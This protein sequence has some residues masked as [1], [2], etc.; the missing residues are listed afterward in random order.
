MN[1]T[2]KDDNGDRVGRLEFNLP[3]TVNLPAA[4]VVSALIDPL[5]AINLQAVADKLPE[6]KQGTD[7]ADFVFV[8]VVEAIDIIGANLAHLCGTCGCDKHGEA[9]ED[10]RPPGA[11]LQ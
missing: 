9:T 10:Q 8:M 2:M 1:E 3:P 6:I 4:Q 5:R 11:T 7:L